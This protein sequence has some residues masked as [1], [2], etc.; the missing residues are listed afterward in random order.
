MSTAVIGLFKNQDAARAV[1]NELL[2][3]GCKEDKIDILADG[4]EERV[5]RDLIGRGFEEDRARVY[6]KAVHDKGAALVAADTPDEVTDQAL[7]VMRRHD[8]LSPEDILDQDQGA[9]KAQSAEE[10]LEIGKRETQSGKR[11][12]TEISE[13]PVEE[14]VSLKTE[15]VNVDRK[16]ADRPL[17]GEEAD[18]A[19]KDE[20]VEIQ[21]TSEQPVVSK[22]AHVTGEVTAKKESGQHEETIRDS[23]RQKDVKVEDVGDKKKKG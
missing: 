14:T 16:P 20:T 4:E 1:V 13:K 3:K 11:L 19:F 5:T 15:S 2:Q 8:V 21:A 22:Q 10:R 12:K 7:D 17:S 23:V 9:S 18:K 6:G